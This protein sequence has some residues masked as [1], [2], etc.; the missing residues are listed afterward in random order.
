MQKKNT[1]QYHHA[2][3]NIPKLNYTFKAVVSFVYDWIN[4]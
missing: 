2:I 1:V 3:Y 4:Q